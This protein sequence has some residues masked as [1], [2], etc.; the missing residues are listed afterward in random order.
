MDYVDQGWRL[1]IHA[2][3]TRPA[4]LHDL[5]DCRFC[6]AE[7]ANDDSDN[8]QMDGVFPLDLNQ[9]Q[10]IGVVCH[11]GAHSQRFSWYHAGKTR[12]PVTLTGNYF[13]QFYQD[14]TGLQVTYDRFDA[15]GE[16]AEYTQRFSSRTPALAAGTPQRLPETPTAL[17][18]GPA[19]HAPI[20]TWLA[21]ETVQPLNEATLPGWRRIETR[22]GIQGYLP[23]EVLPDQ[24]LEEKP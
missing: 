3:N 23:A 21:G 24:L 11:V 19:W 6:A 12:P 14:R 7:S 13:V 8:C 16:P 18:V 9:Q 4:I 2:D 17:R 10:G 15:A 20:L 22:E 1:S 5:S